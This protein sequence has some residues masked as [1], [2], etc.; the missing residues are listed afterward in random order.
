MIYY[1]YVYIYI[2]IDIDIDIDIHIYIGVVSAFIY[3]FY[4][5]NKTCVILDIVSLQGRFFFEK[6]I[7]LVKHLYLLKVHIHQ[8]FLMIKLT[9]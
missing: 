8:H 1:I 5:I 3:L 9:Y 4:Q 7:F 6:G 2:Y